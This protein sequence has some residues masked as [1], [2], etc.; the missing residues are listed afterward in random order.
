MSLTITNK[1]F[2]VFGTKRVVFCDI[3]FDSSYPTG[4]EALTPDTLGLSVIGSAHVLPRS[5]YMF[6]YDYTNSKLK[7]YYPSAA[8]AVPGQ[9]DLTTPAFD[10]TGYATAAQVVTTTDNQTMTLNECAGMWFIADA[11]ASSPAVLIVS[12]TAVAAAAAVLTCNGVPPVTNGGTYKI[13]KTLGAA[14]VGSEVV[15]TA[16]LSAVTSVNAMFIGR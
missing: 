7:T 4:G 14:G 16:D 5:G 6:E 3:A 9:L 10:G 15:S 13:V 12:N 1:E 8:S 2:T 11:L